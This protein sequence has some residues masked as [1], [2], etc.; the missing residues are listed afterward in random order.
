VQL[1]GTISPEPLVIVG[2]LL[3]TGALVTLAAMGVFRVSE[4]RAKERGL[5]DRTTGS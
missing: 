3:G 1:T 4:H 2:A 5:L